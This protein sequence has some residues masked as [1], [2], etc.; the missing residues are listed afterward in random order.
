MISSASVSSVITNP[1]CG[2]APVRRRRSGLQWTPLAGGSW[3]WLALCAG[4]NKLWWLYS[5]SKVG[6]VYAGETIRGAEWL[7]W[8]SRVMEVGFKALSS[9]QLA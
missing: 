6:D 9:V 3:R 7:P 8:S 4:L 2:E 5:P 1:G